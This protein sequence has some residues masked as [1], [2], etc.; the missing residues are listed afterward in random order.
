MVTLDL[1]QCLHMK[2]SQGELVYR[3]PN[4]Q[5][6]VKWAWAQ[7]LCAN[8][9]PLVYINKESNIKIIYN[10]HFFFVG[11][12]TWQFLWIRNVLQKDAGTASIVVTA[13]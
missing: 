7:D 4:S 5:V 13:A 12:Q 2:T 9:V 11:M 10:D 6:L 3:L 1:K 8:D